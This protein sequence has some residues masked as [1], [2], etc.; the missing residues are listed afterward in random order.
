LLIQQIL[1]VLISCDVGDATLSAG[2][3][4]LDAGRWTLDELHDLAR[5]GKDVFEF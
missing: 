4:T 1:L 2:R 5:H 3:W